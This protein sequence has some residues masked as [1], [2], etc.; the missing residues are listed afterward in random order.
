[1]SEPRIEEY[2]K[3]SKEKIIL[4]D[5]LEQKLK[6]RYNTALDVGC[7]DGTITKYLAKRSSSLHLC[8]INGF[9]EKVLKEK[10]PQAVIDI[11]GVQDIEL[12]KYDA[13][14]FSQAL[15]YHS[16]ENWIP[17]IDKLMNSLNPKGELFLVTN[18]DQGDWWN[19]IKGPWSISPE[20]LAFSY[21]PSSQLLRSLENKYNVQKESFSYSM[22]FPSVEAR[23]IYLRKSC[24]PLREP[25]E[26]ADE[27][28]SKYIS[29]LSPL[30]LNF[31]YHSEVL[32]ITK[33]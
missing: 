16:S 10:F 21:I 19:A 8:E 17:L 33:D 28:I 29:E 15:Y 11:Q 1:M 9:Y 22:T 23:E 14:L 6:P 31:K 12:K 30:D 24:V 7:G 13:I 2:Y 25:S 27:I 5:L 4:G 26:I 32:T 18:S 20:S 3:F